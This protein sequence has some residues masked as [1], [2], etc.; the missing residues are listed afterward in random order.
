L[1]IVFL[2]TQTLH[3]TY[4]L[5]E[6]IK[7]YPIEMVFVEKDEVKP[8]F[9]THHT[10]EDKRNE[11]ENEVW[12]N[13]DN[14][15]LSNFTETQEFHSINNHKAVTLLKKIKPDIILVF[16]TGK[17]L[18]K[19]IATCQAGIINLHGGDPEKYRGLDSH[20]W[21]I[22][23]SDYNSLIVT[24]HRLNPILDDGEII[25]QSPIKMFPGML[26][27][28]LRLHNTEV[29]IKLTTSALDMYERFGKFTSRKQQRKG[30]YYS[31]MPSVLKEICMHKF[32]KYTR[33]L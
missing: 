9:K 7:K 33:T 14:S 19:V 2:T 29:C 12:F 13:L 5:K 30:R 27:H 21:A 26:L 6:L 16:G 1:K 11:Y 18:P 20:L 17:I 32:E 10:F 3:H 24:L 28:N 31:F 23:H 4:F 22:Y 8:Q 15:L 25:L